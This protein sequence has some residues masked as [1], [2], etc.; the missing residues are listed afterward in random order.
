MSN[1]FP[2]VGQNTGGIIAPATDLVINVGERIGFE[3]YSIPGADLNYNWDFSG[4]RSPSTRRSPSATFDTPGTFFVTL[5]V[6]GNANGI[7]VNMFDQR[8]VT[9]L[10]QNPLPPPGGTIPINGGQGITAPATDLVVNAGD[11]IEFEAIR[12]SGAN[13]NYNWDFSNVRSPS[14]SRTPS[15]RF[16]NPGTFFVSLQVTGTN[17]GIPVNIFDQRVITVLQQTT[18]PPV[19]NP[20][21]PPTNPIAAG[22]GIL[23]PATDMVVNLGDRF[24]FEATR[25]LGANLNYNWDFGG[26]RSPSTRRTPSVT[27]D[28]VGTFFVTL[29][30]TG[31]SNGFPV[32]IFDQ[33]VITVMSPN[34]IFPPVTNPVP[35]PTPPLTGASSPEG[36]INQPASQFVSIRVGQSVNF[37]GT[38]FDPL[39]GGPL[40]F[41]WSFGGAARNIESQNP[42][43]ITFNRVGTFVVTLLVRNALGQF[44]P[45]P[46]SVIVSVTP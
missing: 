24:E 42:G 33:R 2:P 43:S 25:I 7:P 39:G 41:Q 15:A 1:P 26:L 17:N 34:P 14:S 10:Q 5:Q 46:P 20:F 36:F 23:A 21:P 45:T 32:N 22:T 28:Q 9:V 38:G 6:S 19:A 3:A 11:R 18:A 27:F 13:L 30:V 8:I 40:I 12:I 4:A 44:D 16:D 35:Q 37:S 31:T 29:Q